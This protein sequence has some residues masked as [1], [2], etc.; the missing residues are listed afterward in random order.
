MRGVEDFDISNRFGYMPAPC[1]QC[2][3]L[4]ALMRMHGFRFDM[5]GIVY[6]YSCPRCGRNT[7]AFHAVVDA[8]EEWNREN[9]HTDCFQ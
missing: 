6:K 1:K 9:K 8:F 2:G 7:K 4:P 3:V 5:E